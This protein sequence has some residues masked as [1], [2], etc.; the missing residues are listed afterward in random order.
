MPSIAADPRSW[1]AQRLVLELLR[2]KADRRSVAKQPLAVHRYEMRHWAA[3]PHVAVKP[4]ATFH[5]VDH[6][7]APGRELPI[8]E[9]SHQAKPTGR[10]ET[11]GWSPELGLRRFRGR[12]RT[13]AAMPTDA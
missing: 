2:R 4:H 9:L 8:V 12:M 1:I 11:L 7:L 3:E 6:T 10:P 5:R 13:S